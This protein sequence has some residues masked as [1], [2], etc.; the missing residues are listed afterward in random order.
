MP[1][2][3]KVRMGKTQSREAANAVSMIPDFGG[4][5]DFSAAVLVLLALVVVAI[6]IVPLLL[7][8]IELVLLGLLVAAGI[9]G[10]TLLGRPWIVQAS[11]PTV[12]AGDLG[13]TSRLMRGV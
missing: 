4:L 3:R 6:V 12:Q 8:G 11:S 5:E 7:F 13:L 9:I 10:R 2:W 1:R